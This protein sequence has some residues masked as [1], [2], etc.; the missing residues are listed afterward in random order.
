MIARTFELILGKNRFLWMEMSKE[1]NRDLCYHVQDCYIDYFIYHAMK[2][3]EV[4][5]PLFY[6]WENQGSAKLKVNLLKLKLASEGAKIPS[7]KGL[8]T[9]SIPKP[10]TS[11]TPLELY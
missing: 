6:R 2:P 1:G 3:Y 4:W 7:G 11:P 8:S 10:A 5:L 9:D